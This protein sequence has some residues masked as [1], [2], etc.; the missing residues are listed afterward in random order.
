[1]LERFVNNSDLGKLLLRFSVG[2]LMLFHGIHKIRHGY[3]FLGGMLEKADLP[4][5]LSHGILFGEIVAPILIVLGV[6]TR[7][8]ALVEAFV[9][10]MAVYLA[11][12]KDLTS[13]SQHGGYALELQF[14]YL[15]GSLAVFFLGA[16]KFAFSKG[17]SIWK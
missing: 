6:Y 13:F 3:A 15:L 9:M 7:P 10:V 14:L 4:A 2:G 1:M 11:H 8:A 17:G 5:Y 16:G 12:S